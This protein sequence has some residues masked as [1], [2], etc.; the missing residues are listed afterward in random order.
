MLQLGR[1]PSVRLAQ[2]PTPFEPMARLSAHLARPKLRIK[3]DDCT[4][5]AAGGNKARKL[6]AGGQA[7]L[8]GCE[9]A[10]AA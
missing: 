1:F 9:P 6:H 5:L 4:G 2:L 8:F 7:G 10:F 3:R